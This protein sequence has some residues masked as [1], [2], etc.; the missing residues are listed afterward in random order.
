MNFVLLQKEQQDSYCF[1]EI[2]QARKDPPL[3]KTSV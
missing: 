2:L 1:Y 3:E